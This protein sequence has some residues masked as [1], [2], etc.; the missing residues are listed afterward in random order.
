M[1]TVLIELRRQVL[2]RGVRA[3][4]LT[5]ATD[6]WPCHSTRSCLSLLRAP[7]SRSLDHGFSE[8]FDWVQLGRIG[9]HIRVYGIAG[10][11]CISGVRI[12]SN[13]V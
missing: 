5:F 1:E 9:T 10:W 3:H 2:K 13:T 8:E 4:N 12:L 11:S 6:I 7:A